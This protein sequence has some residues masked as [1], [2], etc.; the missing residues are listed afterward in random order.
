MWIAT[1]GDEV[2]Y[3]GSVMTIHITFEVFFVFGMLVKLITDFHQ[4]GDTEPIRDLET[5][6][7]KYIYSW[8]FVLDV[9]TVIPIT[10]MI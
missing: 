8:V 4:P 7:R 10:Q 6:I 5:I 9:I 3:D 2:E 1:F